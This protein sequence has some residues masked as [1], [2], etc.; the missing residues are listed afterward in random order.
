MRLLNPANRFVPREIHAGQAL[1]LRSALESRDL[2]E[3][4]AWANDD[5][6]VHYVVEQLVARGDAAQRRAEDQLFIQPS[7]LGA[8]GRP[9]NAK[10]KAPDAE[11]PISKRLPWRSSCHRRSTPAIKRGRKAPYLAEWLV[12]RHETDAQRNDVDSKLGICQALFAQNTRLASAIDR[13][14]DKCLT[15]GENTDEVAAA[16]F[17]SELGRSAK[18]AQRGTKTGTRES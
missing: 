6:R 13:V 12:L 10:D 1:A 9:W 5:N 4:A 2:A 15:A 11:A 17:A 8:T 3:A 7:A 18:G 14:M 16:R